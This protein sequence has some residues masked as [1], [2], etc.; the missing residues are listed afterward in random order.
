MNYN[1]VKIT[2]ANALY[3]SFP[4]EQDAMIH[5]LYNSL[6]NNYDLPSYMVKGEAFKTDEYLY[7]K[8]IRLAIDMIDEYDES[9]F[10]HMLSKNA[11]L[12][13]LNK[14]YKRFLSKFE[15]CI[16]H[17]ID[18]KAKLNEGIY[19]YMPSMHKYQKWLRNKINE[20]KTLWYDKAIKY[21][22]K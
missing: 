16:Q 4:F 18:E 22:N 9:I 20:E 15:K 19:Y 1:W 21:K 13:I 14:A 6:I 12:I 10:N 3:I 5:G 2:F 7:L 11:F 8:D 17:I